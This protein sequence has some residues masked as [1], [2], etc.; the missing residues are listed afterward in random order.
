MPTEQPVLDTHWDEVVEDR[1]QYLEGT[2]D[3]ED[4]LGGCI[5]HVLVRFECDH[6]GSLSM[7]LTSTNKVQNSTAAS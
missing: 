2:G 5:D 6:F 1:F 3:A 7:V 4:Q